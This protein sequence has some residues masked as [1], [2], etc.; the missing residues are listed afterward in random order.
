MHIALVSL[1]YPPYVFGG[2][3]TYVSL[4]S[5]ELSRNQV[6][7]TVIAGWPGKHVSREK[8]DAYL[9]VVRLPLLDFPI[10]AVWFQLMNRGTIAK[11]LENVDVVHSNSPQT[12][13]INSKMKNGRSL[14]VT[15]HGSPEAISAYFK[16][17][18]VPGT[19]S[20]GDY[21]Y[22][23]EFP[24]INNFYMKDLSQS[25]HLIYV[26][27]HVKN[28]A[29]QYARG[30]NFEVESKSEVIYAGIDYRQISRVETEPHD[31]GELELAFVG[32]LFWPKG[33]MYAMQAVDCLVNEMG[34]ES[35]RLHVF[36]AGPL[37]Q[38]ILRFSKKKSLASNVMVHGQV[39]RNEMIK[40]LQATR[41]AVLPSLYEGCPYTVL[42]ANAMGLPVVSFD[43]PWSREFITNGLNGYLS[44]PFDAFKLAENVLKAGRLNGSHIKAQAG[45]YDVRISA[46][47]T[48]D[49]YQRLLATYP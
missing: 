26:A 16:V 27:Q 22:L 32:R 17:A 24:L 47:K 29:A 45:R 44:R 46:K 43:F 31:R 19:L 39:K 40:M 42:E 23:M 36:G 20:L 15:M 37:K 28:E 10:R 33:I 13:L 49:L 7:T 25:D 34:E 30:K 21:L 38:W 12:S 41:V 2:V 9:N 14:V 8:V 1:G 3:E 35:T 5:K 11:L 48:I 6:T 4:L 18:A